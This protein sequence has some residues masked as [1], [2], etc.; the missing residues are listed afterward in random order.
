MPFE[1]YSTAFSYGETIPERYTTDGKAISP[2]LCWNE[3]PVGTRSLAL[4]CRDPDC[5]LGARVHWVLY[6]I[7]RETTELLE[8]VLSE[9]ELA[10]GS[11]HGINSWGQFG[12]QAP[13]ACVTRRLCFTLYALDESPDLIPGLN[14]SYLL[15]TI[16]GHI[17]GISDL[18]GE[19]VGE[20]VLAAV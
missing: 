18:V 8:A 3:L 14:A 2:P 19:C 11:L 13:S 1:L 5:A 10:D 9:A 6:D 17:I 7:P 16:Q 12:Y 15:E 20:R 4:I